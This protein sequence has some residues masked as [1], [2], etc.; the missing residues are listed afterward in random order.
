MPLHDSQ[1][2]SW[3]KNQEHFESRTDTGGKSKG[4]MICYRQSMKIPVWKFRYQLHGKRSTQT[5]GSYANF[6]V[7]E[8]RAEAKKLSARVDLGEDVAQQKQ[9]AKANSIRQR[10]IEQYTLNTL[11]EEYY[12]ERFKHK[13]KRHAGPFGIVKKHVPRKIGVMPLVNIKP[14]HVR[15]ILEATKK[16]SPY[17]SI[18]VLGYL[19]ESFKYA[20]KA[21]LIDHCPAMAFGGEDT[22]RPKARTRCISDAEL[23]K[24]FEIMHDDCRTSRAV[25]LWLLTCTRK[26]ELLGAHESEFDLINSV[27]TLPANR[28]KSKKSIEIP[29]TNDALKIVTRQ[30]AESHNGYLFPAY[31]GHLKEKG[32]GEQLLELFA[33]AGAEDCRTHDLRRT[34]YTLLAKFGIEWHTRER[35]LNHTLGGVEKHYNGHDYFLERKRALELLESHYRKLKTGESTNVIPFQKPDKAKIVPINKQYNSIS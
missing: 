29:L 25:M 20:I 35:C 21:Q 7:S 27:W 16:T 24:L 1:I 32:L 8:A 18:T 30:L 22:A 4:L 12:H 13:R 10:K 31:N 28:T 11:I 15:Q 2:N 9:Q 26:M 3:I 5:I 6:T 23:T 17:S 33:K 34:A 19:K 14:I